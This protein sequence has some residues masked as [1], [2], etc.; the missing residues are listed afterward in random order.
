[1]E[2]K[3]KGVTFTVIGE[4]CGKGRP[5]FTATGSPYTPAK[6][7]NYEALVKVMYQDAAKGQR[8][9]DCPLRMRIDAYYSIPAS[10]SQKKKAQM[11][12]G[13]LRPCKK[14]DADN[15][16]KIVA[17]ALNKIA[18]HDDAQIVEATVRKMY[19]DEPRAVVEIEEVTT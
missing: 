16:L 17:D 11:R 1:M 8:F 9:G 18:Y 12:Y 2:T 10:A 5:R 19:A 3:L 14:P 13:I 6:T 4:P 7:T 15:V